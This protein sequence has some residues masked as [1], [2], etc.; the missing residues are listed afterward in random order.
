[1]TFNT[2]SALKNTIL[3]SINTV[4]SVGKSKVVEI[5]DKSI[6]NDQS[7]EEIIQ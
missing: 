6:K 4:D 5:N 3:D 7:I 1:M 2:D